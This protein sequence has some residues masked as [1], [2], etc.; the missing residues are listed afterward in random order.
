MFNKKFLAL[1]L[2]LVLSLG[3]FVTTQETSA[4]FGLFGGDDD[5]AGYVQVRGSDTMANLAQS[6]AEVFMEDSDHEIS[7]T[8]GGSGTGIASLINDEVDIANV[9]RAMTEEEI[10]QAESN[11]VEPHRY[12]IAMDGLAVIVNDDNP[13]QDLTFAEIGAIY[14]GEITNW[15]EL[16]GPDQEI[17]LYGRQ[18]NSGTFVYFRE[19]VLEAD[20]SDDMRRMNGNAQIVEGVRADEAG[21]GY[22]GIGYATEDGDERDGLGLVNVAVD[23]NAEYASPLNAENVETGAYP[24]ARPLNN[25]ANGQAEGAV[26]D[27]LEFVL[28]ERGQE[29]MVEEGFYPVSPEFQEVNDRNLP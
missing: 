3:V 7:V 17:S 13:V 1:A 4:F 18:S 12:V 6:L 20:Y 22:V 2:T 27:Y 28:S 11:G 19:N 26:L 5:E 14:R 16:G 9:S 8:G 25:Y 23:E 21:I 15:S 29:L 24:L 10:D